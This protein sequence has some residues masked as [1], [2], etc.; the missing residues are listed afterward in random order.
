MVK[1]SKQQALEILGRFQRGETS[2]REERERLGVKHN[3]TIREALTALL[4]GNKD[5]YHAL[6]V[7][8]KKPRAQL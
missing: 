5:A 4:D 8:G 1:I 3:G 6:I 2:L 7:A